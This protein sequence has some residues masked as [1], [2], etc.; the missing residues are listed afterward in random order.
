MPVD[1]QIGQFV[2]RQLEQLR[3]RP[4][5]RAFDAEEYARRLALLRQAM[6]EAHLQLLLVSSPDGMCWLHGYQSRWY[7]THSS[8][9][10]PPLQCTAVHVDHDRLVHFDM[11]SHRD[12]IPRTSIVEDMRLAAPKDLAGWLTFIVAELRA[13]RWLGAGTGMEHHSSVP[14]R[15]I[16]EAVEQALVAEGCRVSDAS[17][18]VRR[19]RRVKS[20][21]EIAV[22]ERACAVC[23]DG[24]AALQRELRPGMTELE[25]WSVLMAA[26]VA[27]GGE[28]AGIHEC[29]VAGPVALGHAI[30]SQR[31]LERGDYVLVDPCGVVSRYHANVGRQLVLGEPDPAAVRLTETMAGAIELL[32]RIARAGTPVREVNA[33]LREYYIDAGVWDLRAW[34]GGY[35][36]GV[37]FPPDWV[38]E[39]LYTIEAE[40]PDDVIEAGVVTNFESVAHFCLIET[41][42]Y[43]DG[44]ARSLSRTPR[45]LLVCAGGAHEDH[46]GGGPAQRVE[47][48]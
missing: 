15:V 23:D 12:L 27:A 33:A 25:A 29:V 22:I 7:K 45:E 9:A 6:A 46:D 34:I 32:C 43:E 1:P 47:A 10:W 19:V 24:L 42:V 41:L 21:A 17:A 8:T 16:S 28:P 38:G 4:A 14:N 5:E 40:S 44:G 31:P 35:E 18:I 30:S 3:A 39:W 48:R 2:D 20:A 37:S 11:V 26:M 36:L 13:E